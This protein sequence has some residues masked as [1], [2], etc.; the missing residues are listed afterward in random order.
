MRAERPPSYLRSLPLLW[1]LHI[2][3]FINTAGFWHDPISR[4]QLHTTMEL[5]VQEGPF[6]WQ[7]GGFQGGRAGGSSSQD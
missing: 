2:P 7:S 5:C 6:Q 1:L 4:V 3:Q